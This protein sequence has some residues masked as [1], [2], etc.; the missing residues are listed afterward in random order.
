MSAVPA[1]AANIGT[2]GERR[3]TATNSRMSATAS[4][5]SSPA[6]AMSQWLARC[7]AG[8]VALR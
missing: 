5:A 7:S 1:T 2:N 3:T 4:N 6:Q 8:S